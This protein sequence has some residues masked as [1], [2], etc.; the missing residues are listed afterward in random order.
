MCFC[1]LYT[2]LQSQWTN[3]GYPGGG[4]DEDQVETMWKRTF[5]LLITGC[6]TSGRMIE[7]FAVNCVI[8]GA[9]QTD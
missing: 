3:L 2:A 7:D 4:E 5:C 8:K 9:Q 6:F 1:T